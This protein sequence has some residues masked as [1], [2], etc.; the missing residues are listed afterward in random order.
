MK[1]VENVGRISCT[2]LS[3]AC[4]API[5]AELTNAERRYVKIPCSK[6]HPN[7][8]RNVEDRGRNLFLL[9]TDPMSHNE[10]SINNFCK[11][12]LY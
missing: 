1:N 3:N 10:H 8:S 6:F 12:L 4:A 2:L 7:W 5:F 11:E 9:V